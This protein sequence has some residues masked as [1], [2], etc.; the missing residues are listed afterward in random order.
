MGRHLIA[1]G[2]LL[3]AAGVAA[4]AYHAHGLDKTLSALGRD[5]NLA[6]RM[7]WFETAVRYQL[8]HA[9]AVVLV[10]VMASQGAPTSGAPAAWFFLSGVLLFCGTLYAMTF[11]SDAWRWLGAVTPAGGLSLIAGWLVLA[12]KAMK[13]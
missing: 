10:G 13:S 8:F 5:V 2:A 12:W 7:A 1:V 3:A 11:L 9:L 6:T 4:G